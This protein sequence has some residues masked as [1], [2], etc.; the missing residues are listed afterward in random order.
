MNNNNYKIEHSPI[1]YSINTVVKKVEEDKDY[2][3][4]I[5]D[6]ENSVFI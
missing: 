1:I 2:Q 6:I 4:I 5:K 3:S